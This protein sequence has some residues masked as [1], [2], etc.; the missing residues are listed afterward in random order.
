[1]GGGGGGGIGSRASPLSEEATEVAFFRV[2]RVF[3]LLLPFFV[4]H[5]TATVDMPLAD[6]FFS[7]NITWY[8][9]AVWRGTGL[10]V[11]LPLPPP[12]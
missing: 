9:L 3:G 12:R 6:I 8:L 2:W 1:M 5:G 11:F 10:L 7:V 4:F